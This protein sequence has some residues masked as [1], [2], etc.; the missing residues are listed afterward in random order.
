MCGQRLD[1]YAA[2]ELAE[3]ALF[4]EHAEL[5]RVVQDV[6]ASVLDP[7]DGPAAI[8]AALDVAPDLSAEEEAFLKEEVEVWQQEMKELDTN[9][10]EQ[11][12]DLMKKKYVAPRAFKIYERVRRVP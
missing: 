8:R 12:D 5:L 3:V 10:E 4:L 11:R 6:F 7:L 9:E 1:I 2:A